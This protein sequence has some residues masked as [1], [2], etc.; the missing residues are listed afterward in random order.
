MNANLA[1]AQAMRELARTYHRVGFNIVPLGDDKRPVITG[2]SSSGKPLRFLWEQWQTEKQTEVLFKQILRPAWWTQVQGVAAVCGTVSGDLACIDFDA[3]PWEAVAE[4]LE[5]LELPPEYEWTVKT[6]GNGWHV[7]LYCTDLDGR[8]ETGK[9]RLP[10]PHG[11][12]IELRYTGHYAALPG[13]KHPN[14]GTYEF[15]FGEPSEGPR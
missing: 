15:A 10:S 14:G 1:H 11:G 8:I 4:L 12:H 13:S 7:W 5:K 6:P 9:L 3:T 2:V